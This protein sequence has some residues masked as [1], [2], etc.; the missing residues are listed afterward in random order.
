MHETQTSAQHYTP[1]QHHTVLPL[2]L[3]AESE[4]LTKSAA[5]SSWSAPRHAEQ[6]RP[7]AKRQGSPIAA[8]TQGQAGQVEQHEPK[9]LA[10]EQPS[11]VGDNSGSIQH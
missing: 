7:V 11:S 5:Q 8:A 1:G 9:R 3:A 10:A 6:P 4:P 2:S